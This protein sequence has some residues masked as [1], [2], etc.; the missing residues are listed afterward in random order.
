[1]QPTSASELPPQHNMPNSCSCG[2]EFPPDARA[3]QH[4]NTCPK[5]RRYG[6]TFRHDLIRDFICRTA[7]LADITTVKE[8]TWFQ[9]RFNRRTD[10]CCFLP[11]H[12]LHVDVSGLD[13]TANTHFK[14]AAKK[15]LDASRIRESAKR[16]KYDDCCRQDNADFEPFVFETFGA[17]APGA[18][19]I[20]R[21]LFEISSKNSVQFNPSP[22]CE[23]VHP[24][25]NPN[26]NLDNPTSLLFVRRALSTLIQR[27]NAFIIKQGL[28]NARQVQHTGR[29]KIIHPPEWCTPPQQPHFEVSLNVPDPSFLVDI[30]R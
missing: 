1:M 2:F 6:V 19:K 22:K 17:L 3:L 14:I 25:F 23:Y 24:A 18:Q 4:F 27:G 9:R 26:L 10:F 15:D 21:S 12:S 5:L 20:L 11:S 29:Q 30:S 16:K 13:P 7:A 28:I 8:P